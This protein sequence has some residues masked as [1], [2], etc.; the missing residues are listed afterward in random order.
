MGRV[1]SIKIIMLPIQLTQ[2]ASELVSKWSQ[3]S[4]KTNAPLT[5][6]D[7]GGANVFANANAKAKAASP[8]KSV[9]DPVQNLRE[10]PEEE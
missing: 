2:R 3:L 4:D 7:G 6:H 10:P 8:D 1:G 9:S 5:L